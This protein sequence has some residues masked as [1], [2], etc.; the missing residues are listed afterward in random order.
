M[1]TFMPT[2]LLTQL[3]DGGGGVVFSQRL[4]IRHLQGRAADP[5]LILVRAPLHWGQVGIAR[6]REVLHL[7]HKRQYQACI[8][9]KYPP[10]YIMFGN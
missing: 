3:P 1:R 9:S 10:K 6:P 5:V 7:G 8:V 2:P 4:L